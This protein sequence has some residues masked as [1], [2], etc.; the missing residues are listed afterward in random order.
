MVEFQ[1]LARRDVSA[2]QW[3]QLGKLRAS[4]SFLWSASSSASLVGKD[5]KRVVL[6]YD[7]ATEQ[8]DWHF[9]VGLATSS[10]NGTARV[11]WVGSSRSVAPAG[12]RWTT[13]LGLAVRSAQPKAKALSLRVQPQLVSRL[14][15]QGFLVL[16][17]SRS[18]AWRESPTLAPMIRRLSSLRDDSVEHAMTSVHAMVF[19]DEVIRLGLVPNE[20]SSICN[21]AR[22]GVPMFLRTS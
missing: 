3:E 7:S 16:K 5:V 22:V 15:K 2:S 10:V 18:L 6:S 12:K 13:L 1:S 8:P 9:A 20:A 17:N 14:H 21:L 11:V 4:F 19:L